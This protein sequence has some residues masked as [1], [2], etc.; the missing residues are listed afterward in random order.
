MTDRGRSIALQILKAFRRA[1]S[2]LTEKVRSHFIDAALANFAGDRTG[3][4]VAASWGRQGSFHALG[5]AALDEANG[6]AVALQVANAIW[7]KEVSACCQA[8]PALFRDGG[9]Y[10]A[11]AARTS[12]L[13]FRSATTSIEF[14][15][16]GEP[17][18]KRRR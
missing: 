1:R 10:A 16:E 3:A 15:I 2:H 9:W 7:P 8:R 6:V 5:Q 11:C 17:S 12:T 14:S 4:R 18:F 13:S